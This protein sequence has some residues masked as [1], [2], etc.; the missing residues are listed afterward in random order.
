MTNE[1]FRNA[2]SLLELSGRELASELGV[3]PAAISRWRADIPIP[4][5]IEKAME[6]LLQ[7]MEITVPL[8]VLNACVE[9]SKARGVSVGRLITEALKAMAQEHMAKETSPASNVTPM[10]GLYDTSAQTEPT[11]G[12]LVAQDQKEP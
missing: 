11:P 9:V 3:H 5:Y 2:Q 12:A 6:R 10:P 4:D 8:D 1:E 7:S